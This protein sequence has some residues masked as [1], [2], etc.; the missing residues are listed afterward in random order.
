[1]SPR[2]TL[3]LLW[4]LFALWLVCSGFFV[5]VVL[6]MPQVPGDGPDRDYVLEVPSGA[7]Y[8][9]LGAL[10][11]R[12]QVIRHPRAWAAYMRFVSDAPE[13]RP[14]TWVVNRALTP[15][16]MFPRFVRGR[17]HAN[18]KVLV[19]EGFTQF[20]VTRRF[21]R[22]GI[23]SRAAM[24]SA[25]RDPALLAELGIV[26]PSAEGYLFPAIYQLAQ[27]QA[28]SAVIKRMVS[29]FKKRTDPLFAQYV[30]EH[31]ADPS[32]FTPQQLLTLASVVEREAH[33]PEEQAII[34]GVFVNRLRD[35]AFRPHRLQ[36]DPTAAYGCLVEKELPS[37]AG[38]DGKRVTPA[39]V[40]DPLNAYNTYR[41]EGLPP[42]PISNPGLS[43]LK[44][45]IAPAQHTFFYFVAKGGGKHAFSSTLDEHNAQIRATP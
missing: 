34:A 3:R 1:M 8:E 36:A 29:T 32:A 15:A 22:F 35:P 33:A 11:A 39:M 6:V 38:F 16:Q 24:L 26:G 19:P 25:L 5:W 41:I 10:L 14:S 28:P 20:D 45:A 42:G 13:L 21:E 23:V 18:V 31:G 40:R 27:D 44:A 4:T 12:E 9:E 30:A 43:A 37:C 2:A 7:S 17:G